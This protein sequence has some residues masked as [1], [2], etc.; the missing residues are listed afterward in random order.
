LF[1]ADAAETGAVGR[2]LANEL[3]AVGQGGKV[4]SPTVYRA[5]EEASVDL[6]NKVV[7]WRKAAQG[8]LGM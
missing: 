6:G 8:D 4:G 3:T 2:T 1:L 7:A 5:Y